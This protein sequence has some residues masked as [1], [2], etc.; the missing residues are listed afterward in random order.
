MNESKTWYRDGHFND[1][2]HSCDY[3]DRGYGHARKYVY[4]DGQPFGR[5]TRDIKVS[6]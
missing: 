1:S 3:R 6:A 5:R 2:L 4:V